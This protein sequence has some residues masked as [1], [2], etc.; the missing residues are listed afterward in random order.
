MNNGAK[1]QQRTATMNNGEKQQ[2][3]TPMTNT[4]DDNGQQRHNAS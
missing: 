3:R 1:Q 4:S 2:R